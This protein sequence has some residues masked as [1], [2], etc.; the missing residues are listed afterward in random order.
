MKYIALG[1][2]EP[3]NFFKG[4]PA[5]CFPLP[6]PMHGACKAAASIVINGDELFAKDNKP[7]FGAGRTPWP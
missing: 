3:V 7:L 6:N 5:V 1:V 4:I 2:Y